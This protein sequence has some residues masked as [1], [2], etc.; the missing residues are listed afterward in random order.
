MLLPFKI[1]QKKFER[2][3][4]FIWMDPKNGSENWEIQKTEVQ[5]SGVK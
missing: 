3:R 4:L 5:K 1:P 2:S